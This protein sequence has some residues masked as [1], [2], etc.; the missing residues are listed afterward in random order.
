MSTPAAPRLAA[1][2]FQSELGFLAE[3]GIPNDQILRI[4]TM[5]GALALGL[6][7]EIGSVEA[8]KLADLLI[9]DGDPLARITDAALI[10][11]VVLGGTWIDSSTLFSG[12]E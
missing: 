1:T 9:I 8:G 7:R 12:S 6:D 2:F 3:A 11:A 4:A 10:R 5:E